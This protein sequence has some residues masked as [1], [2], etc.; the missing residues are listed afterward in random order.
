[1]GLHQ[2]E[3]VITAALAEECAEVIQVITK[4]IRFGGNWDEIP[5]GKDQSRWQQ[6][7]SEMNDVLY[8]WERLKAERNA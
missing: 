3:G 5:P 8:M 6:L 4:L 7:E 1:M 2:T